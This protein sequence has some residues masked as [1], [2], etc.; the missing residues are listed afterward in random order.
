MTKCEK[1][2][3]R[4]VTDVHLLKEFQDEVDT[5][6]HQLVAEKH[7]EYFMNLCSLCHAKIHGNDPKKSDLKRLV[8]LRD[9]IIKIQTAL[10]NQQDGFAGIELKVPNL[11]R[12]ALK[13]WRREGDSI[14]NKIKR[15]LKSGDYPIYEKWLKNIK[16]IAEITA[17]KL[18]AY[19]NLE[20]SP[21][22]SSLWRYCGLDA[23][24]IK[25][26]NGISEEEAK[27]Y[28]VPYL[29]K[30]LLGVLGDNFIRERTP[31]YRDIYDRVKEKELELMEE[32]GEG[33][34]IGDK[35]TVESRGHA[36]NRARRKAVKIFVSHYWTIGRQLEGMDTRP[37]YVHEKLKH[38]NYIK[39]PE[40][41]K[42]LKPFEPF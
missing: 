36:H 41:P 9:R 20:D 5:K 29:K 33:V 26:S 4:E 28:G 13:R 34:E 2:G 24:H 1:C 10:E 31:V 12:K 6:N 23:T 16:G 11:W 35:T 40:I 25:R 18:I 15:K 37:P 42:D 19:I 14:E 30:E 32:H 21:T 27:R 3:E 17:A 7:P 38:D 8:V 22:V 39:P